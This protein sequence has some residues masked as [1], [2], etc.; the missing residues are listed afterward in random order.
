MRLRAYRIFCLLQAYSLLSNLMNLLTRD[1]VPGW[2]VSGFQPFGSI[3]IVAFIKKRKG[4][5]TCTYSISAINE[6]FNY[7]YYRKAESLLHLSLGAPP[8]G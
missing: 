5:Y 1:V 8:Q 3:Q 2:V 4:N 7:F 6:N